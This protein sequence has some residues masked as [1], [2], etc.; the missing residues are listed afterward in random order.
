MGFVFGMI[1]S[2]PFDIG[3]L[4][5]ICVL[6]FLIL[7]EYLTSAIDYLD[8]YYPAAYKMIQKVYKEMM[9]M[10]V[11]SFSVSMINTS[12]VLASKKDGESWILSVDF[13]HVCLFFMALFFVVHACVLIF[14]SISLS[15]EYQQIH[16]MDTQ[17]IINK[18]KEISSTFYFHWYKSKYIPGSKLRKLVEFKIIHIL[19]KECYLL[20][21]SF[22]YPL[23]LSKCYEKYALELLEMG[24][25]SYTILL[26]MCL[27]NY[28]IHSLSDI[29]GIN[30]PRLSVG[31]T[32][33]WCLPKIYTFIGSG[34]LMVAWG[35]I[36]LIIARIVELR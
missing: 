22:N 5:F 36:V 24:V 2:L 18:I 15:T 26:L 35:I 29:Q 12:K 23:Y 34:Y 4:G 17:T 10:G 11:V 3:S 6:V 28:G 30:C 9:I 25:F 13:A 27:L 31:G 32:S 14:L 19:F 20:P 7:F 1:E 16:F 21:Q 8:D 33:S